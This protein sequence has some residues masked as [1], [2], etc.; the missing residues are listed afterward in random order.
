MHLARDKSDLVDGPSRDS[1]KPIV[2]Q[3]HQEF[4]FIKNVEQAFLTWLMRV[5]CEI[6]KGLWSFKLFDNAEN[7]Q[8]FALFDAR[9]NGQTEGKLIIVYKT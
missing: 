6:I 3:S 5:P 7:G 8:K 1:E 2:L 4:T 9:A